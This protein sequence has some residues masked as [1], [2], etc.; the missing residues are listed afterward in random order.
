[1][2]LETSMPSNCPVLVEHS[3]SK[4][5]QYSMK[6]IIFSFLPLV[7][8]L[9]PPVPPPVVFTPGIQSCGT[10][11]IDTSMWIPLDDPTPNLGFRNASA[12][13]CRLATSACDKVCTIAPGVHQSYQVQ[14]ADEGHSEGSHVELE[15]NEA[16]SLSLQLLNDDE[17]KNLTFDL[18]YCMAVMNN[19]TQNCLKQDGTSETAGGTYSEDG[20]ISWLVRPMS[21]D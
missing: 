17:I 13:L 20:D 3:D 7:S 12:G 6:Y 11:R 5:T 4:K 2:C 21:L 15:K 1:M 16:G 18:D 19:F 9:D 8:S 14:Y 10:G